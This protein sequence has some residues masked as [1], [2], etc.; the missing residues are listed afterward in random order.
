MSGSIVRRIRA[1]VTAPA[2]AWHILRSYPHGA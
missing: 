1:I 2:V